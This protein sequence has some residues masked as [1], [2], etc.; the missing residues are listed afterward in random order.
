MA[1]KNKNELIDSQLKTRYA[2]I[3]LDKVFKLV[4]AE[5]EGNMTLLVKFMNCMLPAVKVHEVTFVNKEMHGETVDDKDCVFDVYCTTDT[6]EHILIEMQYKLSSDFLD[7]T[8]FYS[9]YPIRSQIINRIKEEKKRMEEM[10]LRGPVVI[11]YNLDAVHVVSIINGSLVHD[12]KT[13][14]EDGLICRYALREQTSGEIMTRALDFTVMELDR[15]NYGPTHPEK[16]KTLVQKVAFVLKYITY[17]NEQPEELK[18]DLLDDLFHAVE[19]ASWS[20]ERKNEYV[21]IMMTASDYAKYL[22]E[23]IEKNRKEIAKALLLKDISPEVTSESTGL[24]IEVLKS[25]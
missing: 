18:G 16:C 25:L 3:R 14:L 22:A 4:F 13:E 21:K 24:S 8:L 6:N 23:Q 15:M 9:T 11:P 10:G 7:R 19:M 2:D 20:F 12:K 1:R 5:D 17:F